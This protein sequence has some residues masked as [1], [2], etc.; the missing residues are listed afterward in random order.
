MKI[1]DGIIV[2]LYY[3]LYDDI[4][5]D[6]IVKLTVHVLLYCN[7]ANI[8]YFFNSIY[9]PYFIDIRILNDK[10]SIYCNALSPCSFISNLPIL[11]FS[12]HAKRNEYRLE[13]SSN[14]LYYII[15]KSYD[16]N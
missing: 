5:A 10:Q 4:Y 15:I 8:K 11:R 3:D 16:S 13:L 9:H 6:T 14:V 12:L 1:L 7:G 2:K